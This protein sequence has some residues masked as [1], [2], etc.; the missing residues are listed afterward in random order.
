M[1]RTELHKQLVDLLGRPN[2]YYQPPE[3]IKLSYPCIIYSYDGD[4]AIYA[5]DQY[6][7]ITKKYTVT[8]I[9]SDADSDL[10]D[11]IKR[12]FKY[13]KFNRKFISDNLYHFVLQLLY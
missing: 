7:K 10:Q 12:H 9:T 11:R 3:T 2:V 6:Y 13:C 8:V 4:D 1:D 5:D